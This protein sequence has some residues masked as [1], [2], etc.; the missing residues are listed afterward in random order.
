MKRYGSFVWLVLFYLLL[1]TPARVAA[2]ATPQPGP[3]PTLALLP[4]TDYTFMLNALQGIQTQ[5]V[6]QQAELARFEAIEEAH[7]QRVGAAW[8]QIVAVASPIIATL[9]T[10]L[11]R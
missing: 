2:Q 5:L 10:L 11:K 9:I 6:V 7:W 4:S 3:T 1:L 8:K